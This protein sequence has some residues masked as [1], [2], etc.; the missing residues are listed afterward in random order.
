MKA[1]LLTLTV[2]LAFCLAAATA[3]PA[4]AASSSTPTP[5]S[6]TSSLNTPV[7]PTLATEHSKVSTPS[8]TITTPSV[9]SDAPTP[10]SS[11]PVVKPTPPSPTPTSSQNMLVLWQKLPNG[12]K[13]PQKLIAYGLQDAGNF[14]LVGLNK[15]ATLAST[16][17]QVDLYANDAT[18]AKLIK[19]GILN[20][21]DE[22]WPGG[23][24]KAEFSNVFCTPA[25]PV[26]TPPVVTPPVVTPPVVTPPVVTPP[27]VSVPVPVPAVAIPVAA[28]TPDK[29]LAFTGSDPLMT[30][31]IFAGGALLL[32][33]GV[34]MLRWKRKIT[35]K[36]SNE[37]L[38]RLF[39]ENPDE[40]Y[41]YNRIQAR[42][43]AAQ[44]K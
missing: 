41:R 10:G 4:L 8:S 6:G 29:S 36:Y 27:A 33:G 32:L 30:W 23:S 16:C 17:Y 42:L 25:P 3:T 13:F 9:K 14:S 1:R 40:F 31:F 21:G 26:I 37:E 43:K 5:E 28:I 2:G 38:K 44:A 18:T 35:N 11:A 19:S 22:S 15:L 12:K 39:I 24:Y 34:S 7:H 20:G